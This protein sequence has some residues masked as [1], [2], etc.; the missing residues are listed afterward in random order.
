MLFDGKSLTVAEVENGIY[1]M[2]FDLQG[3]S[4]NKFN[5][6]TV[7]ELKEAVKALQRQDGVKGLLLS[8]AKKSFFVGADISE[9]G[10]L[11]KSPE[12]QIIEALM[13]INAVSYTHL[14]LPTKRIV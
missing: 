11:F 6:A 1:D 9:F 4:V 14:T 12:P 2:R 3:S 5:Q 13:D 8:S 10:E 7:E